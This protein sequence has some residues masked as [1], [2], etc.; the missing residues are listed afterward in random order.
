MKEINNA[1]VKWLFGVLASIILALGSWVY[2]MS[3]IIAKQDNMIESHERQLI[4]LWKKVNEAQEKE[5]IAV[6]RLARLEA[7][8]N[9]CC[10]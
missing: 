1:V 5:N 9:N 6:Q 7:D 10:Y 3:G 2:S 8:V 4:N